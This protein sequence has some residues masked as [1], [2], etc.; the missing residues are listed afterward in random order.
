[1]RLFTY[2]QNEFDWIYSTFVSCCYEKFYTFWDRIGDTLAYYLEL[3]IPEYK[4]GFL[5]VIDKM[6]NMNAFDSDEDFK[7]LKG[8]KMKQFINIVK[9][10]FITINSKQLIDT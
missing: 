8:L 2:F 10:L 3:D 9:T 7:Y 5:S 4:V 1:M 6:S